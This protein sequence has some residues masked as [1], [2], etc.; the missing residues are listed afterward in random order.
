MGLPLAQISE[1]EGRRPEAHPVFEALPWR[2]LRLVR[3]LERDDPRA[4][5]LERLLRFLA[6]MG[7]VSHDSLPC[8]I[9][10]SCRTDTN[11]ATLDSAKHGHHPDLLACV[12]RERPKLVAAALTILRG[13]VVADR[14]HRRRKLGG[15][16]AWSDLV[17][18][19]VRWAELTHPMQSR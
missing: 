7:Q 11:R 16:E 13:Y 2:W 14:P 3:R 5:R 18:G 17:P 8:G 12:R 19:A 10:R 15:F 9:A 6:A 1:W 4:R